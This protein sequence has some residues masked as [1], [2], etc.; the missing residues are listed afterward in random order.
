MAG[1]CNVCADGQLL[2]LRQEARSLA[3]RQGS[4]RGIS[5][6]CYPGSRPS[7]VCRLAL[8]LAMDADRF[9]TLS[10]T[11]TRSGTRRTTL[12]VVL[13]TLLGGGL[14]GSSPDA[15]GKKHGKKADKASRRK[16]NGPHTGGRKHTPERGNDR[17]PD[18]NPGDDQRAPQDQPSDSAEAPATERQALRSEEVTTTDHGCRH[19]GAGC[20]KGSQCCTGR[21]I[22]KRK[23]SCD[24][25]NPCPQPAD[26]CKRAV[27]SATGKCVTET[28]VD[29]ITC[30][31]GECQ[32]TVPQCRNGQVQTCVAGQPSTEV[33]D[34]KD[35]DCD[36]V[37]DNG[38]D[39][40]TD[41]NNCGECGHTCTVAHGTATCSDGTCGLVACD[42]GW[43][44]C[45]GNQTCETQLGTTEN[46]GACG[47]VCQAP[48]TTAVCDESHTCVYTC[49]AGWKDCNENLDDGCETHIDSDPDHCGGCNATPCAPGETCEQGVCTC[50]SGTTCGATCVDLQTDPDHCGS[51]T[52]TCPA[53]AGGI[54]VAG[55][56]GRQCDPNSP[57]CDCSNL[58]YC[59]G[60]GCCTGTCSCVCDA[61]WSGARCSDQAPIPCSA[62]ASCIECQAHL[63]EGCTFCGLTDD[64]PPR[65]NVCTEF[66][67]CPTPLEQ[68]PG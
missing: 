27:C 18:R 49:D 37:I 1:R 59:S 17:D 50:A 7:L 2:L 57:P 51:C 45:D 52:N 35:N 46:C 25:S 21:C 47:D 43:V 58:N 24:A 14:L 53:A 66:T 55:T 8:V 4:R 40:K 42:P 9:D 13:G 63:G 41:V 19:A 34:G 29:T 6:E 26:P 23:C 32:R 31:D 33:C 60:H 12:R 36:G 67:V 54:C 22:R 61:G 65:T 20:R 64:N 16:H 5:G 56:C 68:C 30:G 44:N 39:L 3:T 10:R 38:F 62:H 15:L 48:H 11:L 28:S